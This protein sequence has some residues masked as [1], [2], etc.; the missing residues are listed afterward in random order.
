VSTKDGERGVDGIA[1]EEFADR[2]GASAERVRA[3]GLDALV[4]TAASDLRYLVGFPGIS[5]LGP[6]PFCAGPAAAL[7][8]LSGGDAT[9][10]AGEPDL[11]L[12]GTPVDSVGPLAIEEYETFAGLG[13]LAPRVRLVE[14]L[15]RALG[16][17]RAVGFQPASLPA[18][19]QPLLEERAAAIT[20]HDAGEL[21]TAL[22]MRKSPAE[23]ALIRRAIA[24]CDAGQ[25]AVAEL[26]RESDTQGQLY[27]DLRAFVHRE[28]GATVPCILE[29]SLGPPPEGAPDGR[30]REVRASDLVLT[31]IAPR[32]GAYWG[33]SCNTQTLNPPSDE[34]T[35]MLATVR[36]TLARATDAVRPGLRVADLDALLRDGIARRYPTF[37]G[38]GGHGIG[39]DF[40]ESPRLVPTETVTLA[41]GMV[42][43]M[44][45]AIYL[46][47]AAVRL[48]HV[49]A[50]TRDGCEVLSAHL[51]TGKGLGP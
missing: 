7:V 11:A 1:A 32:V 24:V 13:P 47:D 16:G 46:P 17:A 5:A 42:I 50:V 19:V 6:N 15:A 3:L 26:A 43:A 44:E 4:V 51:G 14:S 12:A 49:V 21:V 20:W 31:D 28:A 34:Q 30:D 18:N 9:L 41:E 33:D 40:Q 22:R 25:A 23:L 29:A 8:I 48:E 45:P 10:C 36:D 37:T 2:R 35:A 38:G 39:L 27:D